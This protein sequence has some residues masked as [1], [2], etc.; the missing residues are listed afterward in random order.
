ML[1]M[2][3][4]TRPQVTASGLLRVQSLRQQADGRSGVRVGERQPEEWGT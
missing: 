3:A 2:A 1:R 4:C